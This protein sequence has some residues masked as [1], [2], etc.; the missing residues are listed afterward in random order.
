MQTLQSTPLM[1]TPIE[2]S[3]NGQPCML[4]DEL[5]A[6]I[7]E[8]RSEVQLTRV[9]QHLDR[10]ITAVRLDRPRLQP[11][12]YLITVEYSVPDYD[13]YDTT[14]QSDFREALPE[15]FKRELVLFEQVSRRFKITFPPPVPLSDYKQLFDY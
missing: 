3:Y 13:D 10:R 6:S 5:I 4:D 12:R 9:L 7:L 8:S 11:R 14:L 15:T 1:Y 2:V